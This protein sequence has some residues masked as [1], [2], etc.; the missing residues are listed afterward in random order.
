[1]MATQPPAEAEVFAKNIMSTYGRY[2]I[3][4]VK[5]VKRRRPRLACCWHAHDSPVHRALQCTATQGVDNPPFP[6]HSFL[7]PLDGRGKGCTLW[8]STG[9]EYLDFVAGI[10]TCC[11]GHADQRLVTYANFPHE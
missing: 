8:D 1:M 7:P 10:S 6:P 5:C 3:T 9:K 2:P 4:M 11:L